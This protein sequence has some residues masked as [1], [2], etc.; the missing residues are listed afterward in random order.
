MAVIRS[1]PM[2]RHVGTAVCQ[3]RGRTL[4]ASRSIRR[5]S[6]SRDLQFYCSSNSIKSKKIV[7]APSELLVS[8][9]INMTR[10]LNPIL[11]LNLVASNAGGFKNTFHSRLPEVQ[12]EHRRARL[13]HAA[14]CQAACGTVLWPYPF[15]PARSQSQCMLSTEF[16][17]CP[18]LVG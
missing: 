11:M 15:L 6:F 8:L 4:Q 5:S 1:F 3:Q 18:T 2:I 16:P 12:T 14:F 17:A 9:L 13:S 10:L 7:L